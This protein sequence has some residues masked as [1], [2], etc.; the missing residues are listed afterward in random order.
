MC[1]RENMLQLVQRSGR[2]SKQDAVE[3]EGDEGMNDFSCNIWNRW[4]IG[5]QQGVK[6]KADLEMNLIFDGEEERVESRMTHGLLTSGK[7]WDVK[8][9]VRHF[10]EQEQFSFLA[11]Q[12][13]EPQRDWRLTVTT[14]ALL[15]I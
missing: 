13:E 8:E 15:W 14:K 5:D 7:W 12:F 10:P 2:E 3:E 6:K 1:R 9:E 4:L 11:V